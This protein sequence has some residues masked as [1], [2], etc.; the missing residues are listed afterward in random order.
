M[1]YEKERRIL[2][3]SISKAFSNDGEACSDILQKE[4]AEKF[5]A[6]EVGLAGPMLLPP[7][8]R[9]VCSLV[10]FQRFALMMIGSK[11]QPKGGQKPWSW[12]KVLSFVRSIRDELKIE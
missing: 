6:D 9:I 11:I 12:E 5:L 3:N 7:E 10:G 1:Q 8:G 2:K 4:D